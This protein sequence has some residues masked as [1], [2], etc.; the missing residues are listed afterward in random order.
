[1]AEALDDPSNTV[2][3]F[4]PTD[5]AFQK[6][7]LITNLN[8]ST[9]LSNAN[10]LNLVRALFP[11]RHSLTNGDSQLPCTACGPDVVPTLFRV[12]TTQP[13]NPTTTPQ[14]PNPIRQPLLPP[15]CRRWPTTS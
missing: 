2:T 3:L 10:G 7:S 6:L 1:M 14:P 9:I 15:S 12:G 4:A 13:P 5:V 11:G 8:A